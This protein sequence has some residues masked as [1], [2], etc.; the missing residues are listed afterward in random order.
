MLPQVEKLIR[1]I[2]KAKK[3]IGAICIAP[4][5]VA[6]VLGS[7]F[8]VKVTI[9]TDPAVAKDIESFGAKHQNARVDEIVVDETNKVITT[10]A[11]MLAQRV[12]DVEA[13]VSKLTK[14][15]IEL[16]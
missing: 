14:K 5:L 16:S 3:P 6:K 7:D 2:H 4:V 9:G 11:Y 12:S 8:K 15:I 13:G 10:P 1:E